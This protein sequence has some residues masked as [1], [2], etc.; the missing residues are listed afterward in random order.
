MSRTYKSV[1]H[2]PVYGE[3]VVWYVSSPYKARKMMNAHMC[4][5]KRR[6]KRY[7]GMTEGVDFWIVVTPMFASDPDVGVP[8]DLIR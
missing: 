1:F 6:L 5:Q 7:R 3:R 4:D 8:D 2:C